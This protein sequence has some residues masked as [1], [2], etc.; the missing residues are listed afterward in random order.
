[1]SMFGGRIVVC[2]FCFQNA[3]LSN[4]ETKQNKTANFWHKADQ[5]YDKFR[6]MEETYQKRSGQHRAPSVDVFAHIWYQSKYELRNKLVSKSGLSSV[7]FTENSENVCEEINQ[8]VSKNTNNKINDMITVQQ[9]NDDD[10]NNEQTIDRKLLV[11][12]AFHFHGLFRKKF[13]KGNQYIY[14]FFFCVFCFSY[15]GFC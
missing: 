15:Y 7:N 14:I 12:N 10:N 11:I 13:S 4:Y 6:K 8:T 3:K 2:L 9:L 1:M 5:H